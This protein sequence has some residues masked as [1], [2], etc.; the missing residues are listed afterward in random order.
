MKISGVVWGACAAVLAAAAITQAGGKAAEKIIFVKPDPV[1]TSSAEAVHLSADSVGGAINAV[2]D[3]G[4]RF[5]ASSDAKKNSLAVMNP[6]G[7]GITELHINGYDP[8]IS[9]DGSKVAYCS[10]REDQY[11]QIYVA[12]ADGSGEKRITKITTGDSCG[13]VWSHDGKRIVFYSFALT[14]PSRNPAIWVMDPDGGNMKRLAEHGLSATWSPDDR[15]IAFASNRDGKFQIY[16]MNA[17]GRNLR[18]LT[19]NKAEES[20]PAWSPDGTAIAFVS[21]RDGEH[22]ALFL[23]GP[24]G[25]QQQRLIFSKRQDFC[26]P[27]WSLDGKNIAFS[28]L[29]RVGPQYIAVGEELPK[30]EM[31]TGEYQMFVVDSEGKLHQ[32]TNTKYMAMKPSYGRLASTH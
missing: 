14:H 3:A 28:A 23:M 1:I 32:L 16:A 12:N 21:D 11:S 19:N 15:Q 17:D 24:D 27:A 26:F 4:M 30:C 5:H 9:P 7:S 20:A 25:S 10:L 29:N 18:R 22:P 6:D 2:D 31:W 8:T 13:P